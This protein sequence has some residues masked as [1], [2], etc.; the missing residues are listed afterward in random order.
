MKPESW[1]KGNPFG[2]LRDYELRHLAE[3]LGELGPHEKLHRLLLLEDTDGRNAWYEAKDA[4][5]AGAGYVADVERARQ[6]LIA[7]NRDKVTRHQGSPDIATEFRYLLSI[8]VQASRVSLPPWMIVAFVA[9]EFWSGDQ[10][11]AYVQQIPSWTEQLQAVTGLTEILNGDQLLSAQKS[12]L[13]LITAGPRRS[14]SRSVV[15]SQ[16]DDD[17]WAISDYK[18]CADC[19]ETVVPCL[20]DALLPTALASAGKIGSSLWYIRA[21]RPALSRPSLA[22]RFA[23][24][25]KLYASVSANATGYWKAEELCVLAPLASEGQRARRIEEALQAAI[26]VLDDFEAKRF[27]LQTPITGEF[28]L[29]QTMELVWEEDLRA[30]K[31]IAS[32]LTI[33]LIGTAI[34]RSQPLSQEARE[35]ALSVLLPHLARMGGVAKAMDCAEEIKSAYLRNVALAGILEYLSGGN[36]RKVLSRVQREIETIK[37]E[38]GRMLCRRALVASIA[39]GK[40]VKYIKAMLAQQPSYL[41]DLTPAIEAMPISSRRAVFADF[42]EGGVMSVKFAPYLSRQTVQKLLKE[43]RGLNLAQATAKF[44]KELKR[45]ASLPAEVT[46]KP[47]FPVGKISGDLVIEALRAADGL[48]KADRARAITLAAQIMA[49]DKLAALLELVPAIQH[50]YLSC[51]PLAAIMS[52]SGAEVRASAGKKLLEALFSLH[53]DIEGAEGFFR[54]AAASG[55][56]LAEMYE[57]LTVYLN[58]LGHESGETILRYVA[59]VATVVHALGGAQAITEIETAVEIVDRWWGERAAAPTPPGSE[60]AGP[61]PGGSSEQSKNSEEKDRFEFGPVPDNEQAIVVELVKILAAD[62][63]FQSALRLLTEVEE[64]AEKDQ[65]WEAAEETATDLLLSELAQAQEFGRCKELLKHARTVSASTWASL[66]RNYISH[67]QFDEARSLYEDVRARFAPEQASPIAN[68]LIEAMVAEGQLDDALCIFRA[69]YSS[70]GSNVSPSMTTSFVD[71]AFMLA[72]AFGKTGKKAGFDAVIRALY[73]VAPRSADRQLI[74]SRL[75]DYST[76]LQRHGQD[77][78]ARAWQIISR[79]I[80]NLGD[81]SKRS[82]KTENGAP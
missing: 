11:L 81:G 62:R 70:D 66:A 50:D 74:A 14:K 15:E 5:G 31:E 12:T 41:D 59:P 58:S 37:S 55:M 44:V 54:S 35:C 68:E 52:R 42:Q 6:I 34:A 63:A 20:A 18:L 9:H 73:S 56:P 45:A 7:E 78:R 53:G 26:D 30:L 32:Y 21:M 22:D 61:V 3:D 36:R 29:G 10:A 82:S 24:V 17:E 4:T 69:T 64:I 13:S 71:N 77:S 47:D 79:E 19:M 49:K 46:V 80:S 57:C 48:Q 16:H 76:R 33:E 40:G 38:T 23:E 2:R 39:S 25:D 8:G 43:H 67:G 72:N 65:G 27:R 75:L 28:M 1:R 60:E 51:A